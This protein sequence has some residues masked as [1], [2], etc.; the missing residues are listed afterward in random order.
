[1]GIEPMVEFFEAIE[2]QE[3]KRKYPGAIRIARSE[4]LPQPSLGLGAQPR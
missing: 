2:A 4:L 1:M 3:T